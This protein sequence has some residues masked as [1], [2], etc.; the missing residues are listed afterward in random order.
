MKSRVFKIT[1]TD[2]NVYHFRK[3][4]DVI[5]TLKELCSKEI[6]LILFDNFLY[7]SSVSKIPTEIKNIDNLDIYE[8]MK[9]DFNKIHGNK[10]DNSCWKTW[11]M[12]HYKLFDEM[13]NYHTLHALHTV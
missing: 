9:E 2:G 11:Q 10:Y 6:S 5:I 7:H 3:R 8:F 4:K 1:D 13:Y 12:K